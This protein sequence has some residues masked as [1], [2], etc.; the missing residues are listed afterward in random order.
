M[1][2]FTF[3]DV[4][5]NDALWL[6]L[7][8]WIINWAEMFRA[9]VYTR[10]NAIH[11]CNVPHSIYIILAPLLSLCHFQWAVN[12]IACL[13]IFFSHWL[14]YQKPVWWLYHFLGPLGLECALF[15][16]LKCICMECL[17]NISCT[18]LWPHLE[19]HPHPSQTGALGCNK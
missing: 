6:R 19:R 16:A 12:L 8:H 2:S 10:L 5:G 14:N 7:K 11:S 17:L 1:L 9:F 3:I 18:G 4:S 15:N 13:Q